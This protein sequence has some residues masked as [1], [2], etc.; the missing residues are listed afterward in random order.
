MGLDMGIL[1]GFW[2]GVFFAFALF[3]FR[4]LLLNASQMMPV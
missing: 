1:G 3:L 4:T 2:F